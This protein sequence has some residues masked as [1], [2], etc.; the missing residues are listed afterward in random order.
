[1]SEVKHTSGPWTAFTHSPEENRE[2]YVTAGVNGQ[3][4]IARTGRWDLASA[5]DALLIAAAP[6]LLEECEHLCNI[7]SANGPAYRGVDSEG[8]LKFDDY[9]I[10]QSIV[11]CREAIQ[12]T[13]EDTNGN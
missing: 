5:A 9:L 4:P 13:K 6:D 11:M 12:K 2:H 8:N 1:M 10:D 3:I 7:L